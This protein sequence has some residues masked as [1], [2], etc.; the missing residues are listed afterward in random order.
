M[1]RRMAVWAVAVAVGVGV[2]MPGA[3]ASAGEGRWVELSDSLREQGAR[4]GRGG[5][6]VDAE[7]GIVHVL[8]RGVY[9]SDDGCETWRRIDANRVAGAYWFCHAIQVDPG[10]PNRLAAFMKDPPEATVRSAITLDG[11][12]TW[13]P[14]A[15]VKTDRKLT[16]YGWS[17]GLADWSEPEPAFLIA[18]MHHSQ[19]M[20]ASRDGGRRW[21]ELD[22]QTQ[23]MGVCD[24]NHLLAADPRRGKML[25]SC[26]GGRTWRPSRTP[27]EVMTVTG[28]LPVRRGSRV[29]WVTAKGL[30]VSDDRGASWRRV[31]P[32]M[33]DLWWGPVFG[34]TDRQMLVMS[35]DAV[36]RSEDAGQ[37]WRHAADHPAYTLAKAR[38]EASAKRRG[39][40]D[41]KVRWDWFVGETDWGWDT[42]RRRL[43]LSRP[44]KLFYLDLAR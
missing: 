41:G 14:V 21:A 19:R 9:R 23:Y 2:G 35:R 37:T 8:G 12:Q 26:D 20:W 22:L 13:R 7:T 44:G 10:D 29:Y 15:R 31:G 43:Y 42:R 36:Y 32:E 17:W 39:K 28:F 11:G 4:I 27:G 1:N 40:G 18:R 6:E 38:A 16:S 24:A 5:L 33:E 25:H 34:R 3:W 30:A